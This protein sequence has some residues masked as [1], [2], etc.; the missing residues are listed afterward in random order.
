MIQEGIETGF[1]RPFMLIISTLLVRF[2]IMPARIKSA[3]LLTRQ[4]HYHNMQARISLHAC[5]LAHQV[6]V[7]YYASNDN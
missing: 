1:A 2:I 4:V 7:H 6:K 3:C 5:L